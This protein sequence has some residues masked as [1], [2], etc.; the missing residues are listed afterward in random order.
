M[1]ENMSQQ[2]YTVGELSRITKVS[3]K[4]IRLYEEKGLLISE[5]D[6]ANNYRC[7][8]DKAVIDLQRIQMLRYLGFR[9]DTIKETLDHYAEMNL[10]ESFMEQ[11]RLLQKKAAELDRMIYCM[12]RAVEESKSE[13]FQINKLFDSL[14][15]IITSRMADEGLWRMMGHS[16]EPE[17]W[18]RWIFDQVDLPDKVKILDAGCGWGN[19][20]RYNEDRYPKDMQVTLVDYHNSH[21]DELAGY[22]AEKP[23]LR[24]LVRLPIG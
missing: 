24:H 4:A 14:H 22:L 1:E 20:W 9:L 19:I 5:R 2:K 21:A 7:F 6:E 23:Q 11:K 13:S 8:D 12:N 10:T 15:T 17:G 18:S 3:P 16:N